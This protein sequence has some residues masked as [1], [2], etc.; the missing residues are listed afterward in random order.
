MGMFLVMVCAVLCLYL[1]VIALVA[2]VITATIVK[3]KVSRQ[4]NAKRLD[5]G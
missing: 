2:L 4:I 1:G 5:Q 3:H